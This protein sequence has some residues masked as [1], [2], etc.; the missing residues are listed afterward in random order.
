[1]KHLSKRIAALALALAMTLTLTSWASAADYA[2]MPDNWAKAPMEAAVEAGLIQGNNGRL[3]PTGLL[4]R[5]QMAAILVRAFGATQSGDI[6]G[7]KDVKAGDWFVKDNSVPGA[8]FMQ[9]MTGNDDGTFEPNK[10]ITREQAFAVLARALKLEAGVAEDLNKFRDGDKVSS[11]FVG[12]IAAMTK[13]GYVNGSDGWLNPKNN[14]SRQEFAQVM[15]NIFGVYINEAG[16]YTE[17]GTKAVMISAADA[18]IENATIK[19]DVIIGEGV[20]EGDVFFKNTTIE[21]RVVVRGGGVNSIH[22]IS[23]STDSVLV[24]KIEGPVRIVMDE[25]SEVSTVAVNAG[26]DTVTVEGNVRAIAATSETPVIVKNGTVTNVEVATSAAVTLDNA[27]I[28]TL[29]VNAAE[30][31]VTLTN[32][33]TVHTLDVDKEA[34]G[35][36]VKG[37]TGTQV[38]IINSDVDMTLSGDV[39]VTEIN[40]DGAVKDDAGEPV[41]P[42]PDVPL[43]DDAEDVFCT[44]NWVADKRW[45][46]EAYN[47][48]GED[49]D[50]VVT[51]AT[52]AMPGLKQMVC[53]LCDATKTETIA[54][55]GK[56]NYGTQENPI[57]DPT[58]VVGEGAAVMASA[59]QHKVVCVVCGH[60]EAVAH[61]LTAIAGQ[62]DVA[63]ADKLMECKI[64]GYADDVIDEG[65]DNPTEEHEHVWVVDEENTTE[66]CGQTYAIVYKCTHTEGEGESAKVCNATKTEM[67]A[68][69]GEHTWVLNVEGSEGFNAQNPVTDANGWVTIEG[70][71]VIIGGKQRVCEDCGAAEQVFTGYDRNNHGENITD[72]AAVAASCSVAGKTAGKHCTACNTVTEAQKTIPATGHTWATEAGQD[73]KIHCTNDPCTDAEGQTI[74]GGAIKPCEKHTFDKTAENPTGKCTYCGAACEHKNLGEATYTYQA[75]TVTETVEGEEVTTTVHQH[76]ES[77]VCEDCG[78]TITKDAVD[79]KMAAVGGSAKASTCSEAGK[80]AD[81]KCPLCEHTET[82]EALP[83]KPHTYDPATGKCKVCGN[84]CQHPDDS[85]EYT[86][87]DATHHKVTCGVC[88]AV[89]AESEECTITQEVANSAVA[90]TCTTDGKA[91]DKKCTKCTNKTTGDTIDALGHNWVDDDQQDATT[92]TLKQH[93]DR[94]GCDATQTVACPNASSH[95]DCTA[96]AACNKCGYTGGGNGG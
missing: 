84:E 40:G 56:H 49:G 64:C 18:T 96:E 87:I 67:S 26:K 54:A 36:T 53:T 74:S 27:T 5:A 43:P 24:A 32:S 91:V 93:C 77:A 29:A 62:D 63:E 46:N 44:H 9:I 2:D 79:C 19:G 10:A 25:T 51:A 34:T 69:T 82:G 17:V 55:T 65:E 81:T 88:G 8:V 66:S 33:A 94:Q 76:V 3:D 92:E 42:N 61:K 4:T 30:A 48:D 57:T 86:A 21:G 50:G 71:C 45:K 78:K 70:T 90:A 95:G 22:F 37:E 72:D 52:C 80:K 1:M 6:S 11:W 75:K 68:P 31:N 89:V 28:G 35:V 85:K 15:Y 83:L 60:E 38:G 47:A 23:S 12:E 20:G 41:V 39:A 73:G 7:L 16:T 58:K 13:A 14:I 59:K